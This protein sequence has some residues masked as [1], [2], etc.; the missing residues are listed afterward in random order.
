[1]SKKDNYIKELENNL[2]NYKNKISIAKY[3][4]LF[5]HYI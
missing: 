2:E 4:V 3:I 5:Q 1:M